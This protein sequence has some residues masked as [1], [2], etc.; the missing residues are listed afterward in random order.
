MNPNDVADLSGVSPQ[1]TFLE[2]YPEKPSPTSTLYLTR[3]ETENLDKSKDH[4]VV[5]VHVVLKKDDPNDLWKT[6]HVDRNTQKL[7]PL[8]PGVSAT[9]SL[10]ICCDTLEVHG[11]FCVPETAVN[12]YARRILWKTPDAAINTSPL[13]WSVDKAQ[14]A[15][16]KDAGKNGAEGRNAGSFQ[17]YVAET[18]PAGDS[19]PRLVALGGRGQDPGAGLNGSAGYSMSSWSSDTFSVTD[20]GIS[21]S[22]AKINFSPA[23]VYYEYK[24]LW[25]LVEIA[26]GKAGEDKSPDNGTHALAPGKPGN[27]GNGGGL[28]TNLQAVVSTFKN[29][30]GEAGTRERNYSGGAAGTPTSSAKYRIKLWH[31]VFGTDNAGNEVASWDSKNT[32]KGNDASS[33]PAS[34]GAGAKPN[35]TVSSTTNAWLHP[36]GVQRTL[37]YARDVFLAGDRTTVLDLLR[38]YE[39]ALAGAMP[40]GGA[41]VEGFEAQW[42]AVQ[43]EVAAILQRLRGHLDYFGNAAGYMPFLSLQ[44]SMKLYGEESKRALRMLLLASWVSSEA[45]DATQAAKTLGDAIAAL[46][47]DSQQAADL[48]TSS[49]SKISALTKRIDTLE[50]ELSGMQNKLENLRTSLLGK[51]E[52]DLAAKARIKFAI[53]MAAAVCQVIPVGQP[54]LGAIGS[55]G[56]VAAGFVGGDADSAPDTVSQMSKVMVKARTAG[57]KAEAAAAKA[58]KEKAKEPE[59]N[60]KDAK[61]NSKAWGTVADGLGPALSQVSEG[62]K[63]LQVP[64]SEIEAELQKLESESEEWKSITKT[65]RGLNEKKTVLFTELTDA[66]QDLGDGYARISSNATAVFS[67]Q[68]E[69]EKTT[70]RVDAAAVGFV[71]QLAQRSRLTLL[72]YLY[73]MVKSYETTVFESINVDWNLTEITNKINN[74]LKPKD[75]FDAAALNQQVEALAPLFDG[76]LSKVRDAI[77]RDFSF[78]EETLTLQLG[79]S[80]TQV[81]DIVASLNE[82]GQVTIDPV[83]HGLILPGGQLERLSGARLTALEFDPAGP[84]L[85]E[86]INVIVSLQPSHTG[87]MRKKE[88][89]FSVYSDEPLKWSWTRLASGEVKPGKPSAAS[90]DM[91]KLILGLDSKT[92]NIKQKIALPPVW[93]DLGIKVVFTPELPKNKKPLITRLY[94]ELDCDVSSAPEHQCV[95]NIRSI[96][97]TGGA[98][99][100]CTPDLGKRGNGFDR[101]IRIYSKGARVTLSVSTCVGGSAFDAWDVIGNQ[102]NRVGEKTGKVE[103]KVDDNV[104]AQCNWR[105][106]RVVKSKFAVAK[107]INPEMSLRIRESHP[108]LAPTNVSE[109]GGDLSIEA[110]ARDLPMRIEASENAAVVGVAPSL[111]D[112]DLVSEGKDGWKQVNYRGVVGWTKA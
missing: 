12:I 62:M 83:K 19:R 60:A 18:D 2:S 43:T 85:P 107:T 79:L 102:I 87:T 41:W 6:F 100:E 40:A 35:P 42:T 26:S 98:V 72:R 4:T 39:A 50:G 25:G 101:M 3:F 30:A 93:S 75:G 109:I 105:P 64:A 55:L 86:T 67:M 96:G 57:K 95:V 89:L 97:S 58:K 84:P 78:K 110:P 71:K 36:L 61:G 20:S 10:T 103:F 31:N 21:T 32:S 8:S 15:S 53:K 92:D 111:N 37:E 94:F 76:N 11:E 112:T 45:R 22:K 74:L 51:A 77:V 29:A 52:N 46:N 73:M 23:A 16:G 70:G 90:E 81:P 82:T 9:R 27:G 38:P 59:K 65:I 5:G 66:L 49:E 13:A 69:R 1:Q 104:L 91:L 44:G 7:N 54:V 108:D 34:R 68:Q 63:A 33:Q 14:N 48:V 99:V 24:W 47:E 80:A 88:G 28:T 106:A 17:V 56:S